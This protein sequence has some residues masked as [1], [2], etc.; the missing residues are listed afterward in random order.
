ML[1]SLHLPILKKIIQEDRAYAQWKPKVFKTDISG[2]KLKFSPT[3][4]TNKKMS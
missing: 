2:L 1:Q 3:N 4:N